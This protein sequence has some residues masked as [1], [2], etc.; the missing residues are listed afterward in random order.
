MDTMSAFIQGQINLDRPRKIFDWL[1]CVQLI[2]EHNIKNATAGLESD[3][4]WTS[5]TILEDGK[6]KEADFIYLASTWATP[7]LIDDDN[8]EEYPCYIMEDN[9]P[10]KWD[11]DT[12][13]PEEARKELSKSR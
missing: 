12:V 5:G 11:S 13:W 8:W 6:I 7:I 1:K 10:Y 9:N 4:E 2:K 3:L